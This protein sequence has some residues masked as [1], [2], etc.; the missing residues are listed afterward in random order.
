MGR[1]IE[2]STQGH[3]WTRSSF[4]DQVKS[5]AWLDCIHKSTS[6]L[7]VAML[8]ANAG[9][10]YKP[11][12]LAVTAVNSAATEATEENFD[13]SKKTLAISSMAGGSRKHMEQVASKEP[14]L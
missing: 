3:C 12:T 10:A 14:P 13:A 8:S 7:S 1:G 11:A 6:N 9:A 5:F 4:V 2:N